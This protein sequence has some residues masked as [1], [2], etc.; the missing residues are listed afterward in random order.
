M[1]LLRGGLR[2]ASDRL[3]HADNPAILLLNHRSLRNPGARQ[4]SMSKI[5]PRLQIR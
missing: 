5:L 1:R 3:S 2:A 4:K